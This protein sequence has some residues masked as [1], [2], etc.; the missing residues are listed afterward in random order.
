MLRRQAIARVVLYVDMLIFGFLNWPFL[1]FW[2]KRCK[3]FTW[4]GRLMVSAGVIMVVSRYH[5]IR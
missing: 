4:R 2:S 1:F 3:F 5:E